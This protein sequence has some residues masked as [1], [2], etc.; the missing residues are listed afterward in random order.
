MFKPLGELSRLAQQ[1]EE[2]LEF[3]KKNEIFQKSLKQR[4]GCP[5]FTFYEGPPTTNGYPH[6]GHVIGRS[7]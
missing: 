7:I 1:E 6:A 5:R 4:E 3:W 2:V